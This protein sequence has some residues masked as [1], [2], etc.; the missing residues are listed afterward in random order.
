MSGK[1]ISNL[2]TKRV[3]K[4]SCNDNLKANFV[5]VFVSNEINYFISFGSR[6]K[7]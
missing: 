4:N 3:I 7:D 5:G 2:E 6:I 1:G